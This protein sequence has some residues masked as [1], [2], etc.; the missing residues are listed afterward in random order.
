MAGTAVIN[1]DIKFKALVRI[2]VASWKISILLR[3][4]TANSTKLRLV[5]CEEEEGVDAR[6]EVCLSTLRPGSC[7]KILASLAR[8]EKLDA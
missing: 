1:K 2:E 3:N 8:H 6:R 4:L 5:Q 7:R